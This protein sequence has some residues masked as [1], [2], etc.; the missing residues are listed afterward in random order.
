MDWGK[1]IILV[2]VSFGILM[3]TLVTICVRQD[4]MH[5]VTQNYYEEEV[6][7]QEHIERVINTHLLEYEILVFDNK[8]KT[9]NLHLP[10]G[11]KGTIHFFRPSDARLDKKLEVNIT[12]ANTNSIDVK[13]LKSGYW[14]VK[15]TW[16]EAGKDYYQE[17]NITI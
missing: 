11:A 8:M 15:L 2:L 9:M 10:V 12:D 1:A 14:K 5:L 4:D 13:D 16:S 17:K 7:Y 3:G 6:K